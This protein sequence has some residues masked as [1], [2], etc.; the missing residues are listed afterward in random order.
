MK[1]NAEYRYSAC[2]LQSL[3]NG[4][5][6]GPATVL[7]DAV[8]TKLHESRSGLRQAG[9]II[10][11]I[12]GGVMALLGLLGLVGAM[13]Q[14]SLGLGIM[15]VFYMLGGLVMVSPIADQLRKP[16]RSLQ[17]VFAPPLLAVGL[18]MA[19]SIGG[20]MAMVGELAASLPVASE[21]RVQGAASASK[22]RPAVPSRADK[23]AEVERLI[24]QGTPESTTSALALMVGD[25]GLREI[26]ADPEL[27]AL[28]QRVMA[29]ANVATATERAA[30]Y[31]FRAEGPWLAAV[32]A[33][34]ATTP[35][36]PADI[37]QR[38]EAF[39]EAAR[40]I[41]EGEA[42]SSDP[43]AAAARD[44]LRRAVSERQRIVFPVL[45]LGYG[46]ILRRLLWEQDTEVIVQGNGSRT[47]R[48]IA[49]MFAANRNIASAQNGARANA[50]KLRFNR[51]QFEWYRGSEAT[52]Y[53]LTVPSDGSVG[54]WE[55]GQFVEVE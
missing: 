1:L 25:F 27:K 3:A 36:D 48:F 40:Q 6:V 13:I 4:A 2:S 30:D 47:I 24:D 7:G 35:T 15:S 33:V 22:A 21:S 45:R 11:T 53:A 23:L 43:K 20:A 50:E 34:P 38:V 42:F 14:G 18:F 10:S 41:E 32:T 37:W 51:T 16:L 44:R 17:S 52:Y 46:S 8:N 9:Q 28:H 5:S 19:G 12:I 55:A 29:A 49:G 31:A 26:N 54:Y 39:E